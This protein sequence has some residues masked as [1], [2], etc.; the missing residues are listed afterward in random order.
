[1]PYRTRKGEALK[2]AGL[3]N[4]ARFALRGLFRAPGFTLITV[5]TLALGIVAL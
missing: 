4:D 2:M 1:M 3:W 5:G